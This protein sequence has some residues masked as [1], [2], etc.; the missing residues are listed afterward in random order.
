MLQCICIAH[1]KLMIIWNSMKELIFIR[2]WR[3]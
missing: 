1:L 2:H 3:N